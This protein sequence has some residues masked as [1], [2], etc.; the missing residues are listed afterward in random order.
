[1]HQIRMRTFGYTCEHSDAKEEQWVRLRNP[2]E[3][4]MG[5]KWPRI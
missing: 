3:V 2:N 1:M 5:R 4:E